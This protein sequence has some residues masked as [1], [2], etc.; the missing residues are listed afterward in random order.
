MSIIRV[1]DAIK[2]QRAYFYIAVQCSET[3]VSV[4]KMG[5]PEWAISMLKT[6]IVS[7]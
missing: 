4:E 5:L 2:N 3:L 1:L 6:H 7:K